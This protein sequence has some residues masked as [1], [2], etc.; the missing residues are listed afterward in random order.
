MLISPFGQSLDNNLVVFCINPIT[1]CSSV[2][3]SRQPAIDLSLGWP[4]PSLLPTSILREACQALL[5]DPALS[6][7]S[8][9]YGPDP[10]PVELR[11]ALAAFL[12]QYYSTPWTSPKRL[13]ITGGASQS[14]ACILQVFTDPNITQNVY[15]VAPTYFLACRIF[16]DSGFAGRLKAV[17]ENGQGIDVCYLEKLLC[18]AKCAAVDADGGVRSP[19]AL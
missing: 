11:D 18:R 17:P 15:M 14:L 4:S 9:L 6:V 3:P 13:T 1:L 2:M 5:L 10:G 8:L 16:E 7:P 12:G 19:S